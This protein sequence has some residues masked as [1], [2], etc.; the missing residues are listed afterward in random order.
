MS[1]FMDSILSDGTTVLR[2]YILGTDLQRSRTLPGRIVHSPLRELDNVYSGPHG[3]DFRALVIGPVEDVCETK[4]SFYRY[5]ATVVPPPITAEQDVVDLFQ[6]QIR[7]SKRLSRSNLP[8]KYKF[9]HNEHDAQ[10]TLRVGDFVV[11]HCSPFVQHEPEDDDKVCGHVVNME[12]TGC[13]KPLQPSDGF[14]CVRT[15]MANG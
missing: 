2:N 4:D 6:L 10:F 9:L 1:V 12:R 5:R 15:L 13:A 3:D 8:A 14:F 7:R 11:L